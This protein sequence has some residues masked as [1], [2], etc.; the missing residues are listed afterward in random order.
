MEVQKPETNEKIMILTYV[1]MFVEKC[2]GSR[3]MNSICGIMLIKK[4]NN[5]NKNCNG[6]EWSNV[7]EYLKI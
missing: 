6:N 2:S 4:E 7:L 3:S 5:N 1:Q